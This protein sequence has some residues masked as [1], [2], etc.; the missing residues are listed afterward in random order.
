MMM[1]NDT[2]AILVTGA[3]GGIGLAI[4]RYFAERGDFVFAADINER[5]L[6]NL[7]NIPNLAPIYMDV[8]DVTSI[9]KAREKICSQVEGLDGLV[10]NAGLFVG[11]PLIE[12][13]E[14][15]ME[16]IFAVNVLGVYKTT[17]ALFPLLYAKK[18]RI[19]NIGSEASRLVFPLNGPYSMTK[20][21]L[22]AFS[23]ALR[24]ELMFLDMKVIHLQL[25][26]VDTSLIDTTI[27]VYSK[28]FDL[29]QTHF[30]NLLK[31]VITTCE[32][33]KG[34]CAN[35]DDIA[36]AVYKL[37]YKKRPRARY[38]IKNNKSRQM[39]EFFP[40]NM[41]DSVMFRVLK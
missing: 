35:P 22:E 41:L 33:E 34:H 8:T 2:K 36:K 14:K 37:M 28:D 4:S 23:D 26:A 10:N 24:R 1:T 6:E 9:L 29:K 21:A 27:E 5:A 20:C 7:E 40:E 31:R 30:P 3:A 38:R 39:L 15:K 19:I 17:K 11:G 32:A 18:G 25:G 12:V 16:Q 13:S